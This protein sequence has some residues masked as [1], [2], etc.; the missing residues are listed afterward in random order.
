MASSGRVAHTEHGAAQE[1]GTEP[2][3]HKV[4][5]GEPGAKPVSAD[6]EDS[7]PEDLKPQPLA[8]AALCAAVHAS[9]AALCAQL[10][11]SSPCKAAAYLL[12][13]WVR[14]DDMPAG[15][16]G[17]HRPL[18]HPRITG[19][20]PVRAGGE[21]HKAS[22]GAGR[23]GLLD[24]VEWV[25]MFLKV[26]MFLPFFGTWGTIFQHTIP[27]LFGTWARAKHTIKCA[28]LD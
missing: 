7:P 24:E 11:R 17:P 9:I 23:Q 20:C 26:V 27:T 19:R 2:A 8:G 25:W 3:G 4:A 18:A 1:A 14:T 10:G 6:P 5:A 16:A 21:R 15:K 13:G 12:P 22:Q 28:L